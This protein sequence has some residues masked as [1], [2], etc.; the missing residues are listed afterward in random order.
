MISLYIIIAN[1]NRVIAF[2]SLSEF[3]YKHASLTSHVKDFPVIYWLSQ[4]WANDEWCYDKQTSKQK[5]PYLNCY[6]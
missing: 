5:A 1:L 6:T 2:R 3:E 4:A